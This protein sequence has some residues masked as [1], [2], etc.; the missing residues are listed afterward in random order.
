MGLNYQKG[1]TTNKKVRQAF[2]YAVDKKAIVK[3]ILF[4][5]AEPMNGP[6]SP[7]VFGHFKMDQQFDYNP[8][9]AKALLKEANLISPRLSV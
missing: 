5:T 8:D 3:K 1:V 6:V 9:K 4:D 7:V 2:N